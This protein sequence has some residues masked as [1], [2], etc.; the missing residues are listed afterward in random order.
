MAVSITKSPSGQMSPL[1]SEKFSTSKVSNKGD[2]THFDSQIQ[3][4]SGLNSKI[5]F[6]DKS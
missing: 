4:R 5:K 3:S 6:A 2:A 1:P